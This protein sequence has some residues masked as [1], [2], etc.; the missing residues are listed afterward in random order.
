M[1]AGHIGYVRQERNTLL[2]DKGR[3]GVK[4]LELRTSKRVD[5]FPMIFGNCLH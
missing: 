5:R 2:K 4:Y 1:R 3:R